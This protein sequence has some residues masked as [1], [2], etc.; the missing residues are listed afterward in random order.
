MG[1][2]ARIDFAALRHNLKRVRE[3]AP[4]SRVFAVIKANAY[5]HGVMR[6]APYLRDADGL[7]VAR[8]DEAIRLRQNGMD[9]PLLVL[10]GFFGAEELDAAATYGLQVAVHQPEQLALLRQRQLAEPLVCWLKLDSGM[11][12]LGFQP[13]AVTAAWQALQEIPSVADEVRLMTHLSSADDLDDQTTLAQIATLRRFADQFGCACSIAN[14]AG[15][16][17][18]PSARS[19]WIRPGIMLYG[20]SPMAGQTGE[21]I[22]LK[23]VMTLHSEL[24]AVNH[25]AK[26]SPVGYSGI[27]TCPEDMPVGVV[28]TGYGDGYPRHAP[29]G[30][31]VL[32]NGRRVPLIGRVS[33]D[34]LTVDLRSQPTARPGDPVTLWGAGLPAEEV[35][36]SSGTIAYELFCGVTQRVPFEEI[37]G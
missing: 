12:R 19:D 14:S 36:A 32:L 25:F 5:G 31:P 6:V 26:G 11:H 9:Q 23:P 13:A 16:I 33:M 34:M 37:N 29:S 22:D 2:T 10:E 28:A 35:A 27:W 24:I 3:L 8:V 17:S 20:A 30:T 7:A 21:Q 15:I 18:W 4:N 1:P